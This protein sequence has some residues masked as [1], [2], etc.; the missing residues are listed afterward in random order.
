MSDFQYQPSSGAL[1]G[2]EFESQTT[3][4][5]QQISSVARAAQE[6]ANEALEHAQAPKL[7]DG[8]T[9]QAD[10]SGKITVKDVAIGE[11]AS[12]LASARGFFYDK[13]VPCTP[14]LRQTRI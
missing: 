12:N 2:I 5:L 4:F 8:K 9:T 6:S 11:D 1:S 3:Q 13:Y 10:A 14:V 7:V